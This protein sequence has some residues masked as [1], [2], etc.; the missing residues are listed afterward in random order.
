MAPSFTVLPANRN[1]VRIHLLAPTGSVFKVTVRATGASTEPSLAEGTPAQ[2]GAG[3]F[4][5][6]QDVT[7]NPTNPAAFTMLVQLPAALAPTPPIP[8]EILV[9]NR[10]L[11]TDVTDS[12]PMIVSLA[13]TP[14]PPPVT[15]M[16]TVTVVVN[17]PGHVVSNPPGIACGTSSLGNPMQPCSFNFSP[18]TVKLE[19]N[20]VDNRVN[21]FDG[22]ISGCPALAGD[23]SCLVS[24]DGVHNPG[25]VTAAFH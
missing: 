4:S 2:S 15:T 16:S 5:A 6:S 10:S 12:D 7:I 14:V 25:A 24:V 11:R 13:A 18:G 20:S 3:F 1:M 23:G 21:H 17:G 9:V 8:L 22:W 19:P